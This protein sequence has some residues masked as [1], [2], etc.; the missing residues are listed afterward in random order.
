MPT[1]YI[2]RPKGSPRLRG[3]FLVQFALR[4]GLLGLTEAGKI[5]L[6]LDHRFKIEAF[7]PAKEGEAC[8]ARIELEFKVEGRV[9]GSSEEKPQLNVKAKYQGRF[10]FPKEITFEAASNMTKDEAFCYELSSQTFA[11][12]MQHLKHQLDIAGVNVMGLSLGV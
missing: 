5:N 11:V 2:D 10:T 12:A 7:A 8:R 4:N 6:K 9:E 3:V 1:P